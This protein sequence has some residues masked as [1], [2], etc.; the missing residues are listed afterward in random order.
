MGLE[1]QLQK[2]SAIA[3]E[4]YYISKACS[5]EGLVSMAKC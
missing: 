5:N 4:T 1:T 2:C 3:E